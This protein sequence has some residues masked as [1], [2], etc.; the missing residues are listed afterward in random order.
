MK[1]DTS[2]S[3]ILVIS[4]GFLVLFIVFNWYWAMITSLV[5]GIIGIVSAPLSRIIE[6]GWMKLSKIL[7]H[8]IPALLLGIVFYLF[9]FPVSLISKLFTKDPLMLSKGYKTHFV[10]I[11]KEFDRESFKKIW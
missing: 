9:L 3:T 2:K 8:I 7:S 11:N 5:A 1:T 10:D 4:M 6:T